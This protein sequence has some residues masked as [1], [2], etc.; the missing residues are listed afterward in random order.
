MYNARVKG[1]Q[2]L[3]E[4]SARESRAKKALDEKRAKRRKERE[5]KKSGVI[6]KKKAKQMGLWKLDESQAKYFIWFSC[7]DCRL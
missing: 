2:I 4:N 6:S 7:S 5:K 3:L 1:R